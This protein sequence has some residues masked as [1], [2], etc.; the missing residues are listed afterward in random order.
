M[1]SHLPAARYDEKTAWGRGGSLFYGGWRFAEISLEDDSVMWFSDRKGHSEMRAP[2]W[3]CSS[4]SLTLSSPFNLSL[5]PLHTRF[6][7]AAGRSPNQQLNIPGKNQHQREQE[8][9]NKLT[10]EIL[11]Y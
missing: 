6:S 11:R 1:N 3:F 2:P 5:P 8:S 10:T 4:S 9:C 7:F